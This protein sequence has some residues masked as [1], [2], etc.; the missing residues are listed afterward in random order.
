MT[1]RSYEGDAIVVHWNSEL[2]IHTARCLR[3]LPEVFDNQARPWV[4][5]GA[6]GA[7]EIARAVQQCPTAALTY[8]R[9]DG[10]AG[11]A[12]PDVTTVTPLPNGPLLVRGALEV[13]DVDGATFLTSPRAALCRCGAS[14][15]QPFCDRSHVRTRFRD[16]PRVVPE[17]RAAAECPDDV[18][19]EPD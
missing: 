15:N 14:Q 7:D 8:T 13:K 9:T 18:A 5:V 6:A 17:E 12:T 2:C 19:V 1:E 3:A 16:N 4:T 10:A 11:E